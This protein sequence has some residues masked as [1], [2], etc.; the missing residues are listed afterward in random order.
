MD[1]KLSKW[2]LGVERFRQDPA[3]DYREMVRLVE[4]MAASDEV[5]LRQAAIQALP[6]LRNAAV[7]KAE[8]IARGIARR[9]LGLVHD[10]LHALTIPR[11]GKRSVVPKVLTPEER[12]RQMLGL[13]FGRRLA[14]TEIHHAYKQTAKNL[15][16]DGGGNVQAFCD[17]AKAR[18]ALMKHP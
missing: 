18:D 13:P 15:H 3:P 8:R 1:Q 6:S 7:R 17:L 16:P 12:Y 9:R 11:F 5:T 2:K 4:E 14:A 10:A